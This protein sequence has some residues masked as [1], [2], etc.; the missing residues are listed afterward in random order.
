MV[1]HWSG[2][3]LVGRSSEIRILRELASAVHTKRGKALV[4]RGDAGIGKSALIGQLEQSASELDAL[5]V[6]GV[7]SEMELPFGG[8]HQL[9]APL[10]DLLSK[11]PEPQQEALGTVFGLRKGRRPDRLLVGLAA[12]TLLSE[13]AERKPLLCVVDDG[14]W[15]DRASAQALA[16]VGRRLLADPIGLVISTRVIDPEFSGLPELVLGGLGADDAMVLLRSLPGSPLDAQVRD[17]IVA[18]SHGNPLALLEWRRA[19][20]PAEGGWGSGS[21]LPGGGPLSG[22]LEESFRR[23]L[24]ELPSATQRFALVAA[25]EPVGNA[26]LIWRA[27]TF[28][29]VGDEAALP[30]VDAGLIEI[31][32]TVRFTHPLVRSAAYWLLS[33]EERHQAHRAISDAMDGDSDPHRRAWHRGLGT[34]A[35]DAEVAEELARFAE[36]ARSRGGGAAVAAFLERSVILTPDPV[37]RAERAVSAA[38]AKAQVGDFQAALDLLALADAGPLGE[39]DRARMDLVR[40]ELAFAT[41]R[42]TDASRLLVK[43]AKRLEV[44]DVASARTTYLDAVL[45]AIF[46]GRLAS[47]EADLI[48]VAQAAA[49]LP[50]VEKAT[51]EDLLLAGLTKSWVEGYETALP[52]L[53]GALVAMTDGVSAGQDAR[54]L[55]L[56]YGTA[57][58]IWEDALA[59][60]LGARCET[61]VRDSGALSDMAVWL[62]A[63]IMT[64]LLEGRH[65]AAAALVEEIRAI[66]AAIGNNLHA[67]PIMFY[68]AVR[69]DEREATAFINTART[70]AYRR[71]E[72]F[73]VS[74]AEWTTALLH[75]GLGHYP[76]ALGALQGSEHLWQMGYSNWALV[77]LIEAA[78]RCGAHQTAQGAYRRLAQTTLVSGTEWALGVDSRSRALLAGDDQAEPIYRDAIDH[79]ERTR[80]QFDLARAYLL[81]GEWLRRQNRRRDARQQLRTAEDMLTAMEARGFADRARRELHATGET[82]RKRRVDTTTKLTDQEMYIARLV[83]EGLTNSEIGAQLFI[84]VRTVE[85]HLRKVFTKLGVGSRHELRRLLRSSADV[86]RPA[87]GGPDR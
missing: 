27:A 52:I 45:A 67:H 3:G 87:A 74:C 28:L 76:Q 2:V 82:V 83:A 12:L 65:A 58:Y 29:E 38:E 46:A 57:H 62:S 22:R 77:E 1:G 75:N 79:L 60:T 40:A 5:R 35:P 81:Y 43:A 9:C 20:T 37:R 78:T 6:V 53:R 54:R 4:V 55:V 34:S 73:A 51:T 26:A 68:L 66:T 44:V 69:G 24:A 42:G 17:R 16:F 64:A 25:A 50:D 31:A 33:S 10:L 39:V 84:S 30:A 61:I 13:A 14:H 86:T 23:R 8:L 19:L 21:G 63:P 71:G 18:E 59:E 48:S 85:W 72:G 70:E 15:L 80:A 7:E 41:N 56:A 11:L 32:T 49:T 47:A 36:K